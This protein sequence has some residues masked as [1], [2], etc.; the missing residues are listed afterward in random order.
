MKPAADGKTYELWLISNNQKIPAGTF[1]VNEHGVAQLLGAV[2]TL[3]AGSNVTLAV[4]DEPM[5][6]RHDAPTGLIQMAGHV[7]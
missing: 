2:P 5:N 3:P 6:S 7:Q 1:D 4:T